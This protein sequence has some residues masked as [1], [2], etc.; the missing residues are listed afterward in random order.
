MAAA[1]AAEIAIVNQ[2]L[3]LLGASIITAFDTDPT[4]ASSASSPNAE[5][6]CLHYVAVRNELLRSFPWKFAIT[7]VQITADGTAPAF[8]RARRFAL[9]ADYLAPL[10][11]YPED[12][13]EELDWIIEGAYIITDDSSPLDFRYIKVVTD[14]TTM[15]P[16]FKKAFALRLAINMC[17][18]ITQ[19]NTKLANL[20]ALYKETVAEARQLSAFEA[21]NH[22]PPPDVWV[23]CRTMGRNNTRTWG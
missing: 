5:S 21:V 12:N 15:D 9:P 6:A 13:Y 4:T 1:S 16:L 22:L 8:G 14:T 20:S 17:E 2:A 3:E 7:R 11:P 18:A 19:S 23:T 10:A